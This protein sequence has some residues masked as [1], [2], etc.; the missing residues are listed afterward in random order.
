MM[1]L[2]LYSFVIS[3]SD[4]LNVNFV[5]CLGRPRLLNIS[6]LV[7]AVLTVSRHLSQFSEKVFNACCKPSARSLKITVSSA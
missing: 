2:Y 1:P 4:P 5:V 7:L 3:I 6:I